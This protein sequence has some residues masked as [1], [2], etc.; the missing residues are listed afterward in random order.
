MIE[1]LADDFLES[2]KKI[3]HNVLQ[4]KLNN[5]IHRKDEHFEKVRLDLLTLCTYLYIEDDISDLNLLDMEAKNRK[6][7]LKLS[8]LRLRIMCIKVN[9]AIVQI[10]DILGVNKKSHPELYVKITALRGCVKEPLSILDK[11]NWHLNIET[12]EG[13]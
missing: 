13:P 4:L 8:M 1:K 6:V 10:L 3:D 9:M 7:C 11:I 2:V 5:G 12:L